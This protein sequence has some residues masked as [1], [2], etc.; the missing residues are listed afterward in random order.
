[1][2]HRRGTEHLPGGT[3]SLRCEIFIPALDGDGGLESRLRGRGDR[4]EASV[5]GVRRIPRG[6]APADAVLFGPCRAEASRL[7]RLLA[8]GPR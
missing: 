1:M 5:S 3:Q 4:G 6:Q 7:R 2:R 8:G